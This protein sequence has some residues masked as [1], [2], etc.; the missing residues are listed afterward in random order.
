MAVS[1]DSITDMLLLEML[2]RSDRLL[3]RRYT[4]PGEAKSGA[5]WLW[6][7]TSGTR[8]FPV[9]IQAKR[10]YKSRR[11]EALQSTR[12]GTHDQTDRLLCTARMSNWLPLYCFYNFWTSSSGPDSPCWGCSLAS[13]E[14]IEGIL[15][16]FGTSGNKLAHIRP[17]SVPWCHLVCQATQHG[18]EFPDAIRRRIL[19]ITGVMTAPEVQELPR[20]VLDL[21]EGEPDPE[22]T[23][24]LELDSLET[25]TQELPEDQDGLAGVVVVSDQ[26]IRSPVHYDRDTLH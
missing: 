4:R 13:A 15:S 3:C 23:K 6:W 20:Q 9:L 2:R 26:R 22:D 1:E 11:Y 12:P 25:H 17:I 14:A 7:F 18:D 16:R 8:G 21:I 19:G 24:S 10:L 5:D